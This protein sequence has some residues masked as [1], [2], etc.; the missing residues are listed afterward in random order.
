[1]QTERKPAPT[2]IDMGPE[3][4]QALS[5]RDLLAVV[6]GRLWILVLVMILSLGGIMGWTLIQI[7]MYQASIKM[8]IGQQ[9]GSSIPGSLGAD[10]QGLQQLTGTMTELVTGR[11]VADEVIRRQGLPMSAGELQAHLDARPI[12]QTQVIQVDYTDASPQRAQE[13]VNTVG[14]VFS[15]QVSEVSPSANAVTATVWEQA[16]LPGEAV[17]PKWAMNIALALLIG[18]MIDCGLVVMFLYVDRWSQKAP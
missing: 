18:L 17:R 9:Q 2:D 3:G 12:N 15:E 14:E 11:P 1:M 10:V 7:P 13:V 8:L 6:Q 5:L 4:E 16:E